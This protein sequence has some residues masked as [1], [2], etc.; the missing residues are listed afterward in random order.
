MKW[1][2]GPVGRGRGAAEVGGIVAEEG[3][4]GGITGDIGGGSHRDGPGMIGYVRNEG[5]AEGFDSSSRRCKNKI[6]P[7]TCEQ[8]IVLERAHEGAEHDIVAIA[9]AGA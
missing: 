3:D 1:G 9:I 7:A 2:E 5:Q 4:A 8:A 6:R